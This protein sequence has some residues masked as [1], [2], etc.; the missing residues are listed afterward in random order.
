MIDW[1][2]LP[3]VPFDDIMTIV[4]HKSLA[5]LQSCSEVCTTWSV[6]IEKDIF[7]NP[8][9]MGTIRDK[10]ERAFGPEVK[11]DP[12]ND[13]GSRMLPNNEMISNAKWL[14]KYRLSLSFVDTHI[15]NQG[16]KNLINI[17]VL[18]SFAARVRKMLELNTSSS[19]SLLTCAGSLAFHGLLGQGYISL[20]LVDVNLS[21]VPAEYLAALARTLSWCGVTKVRGNDLISFLSHLDCYGLTITQSLSRDETQALVQAMES[22]V[23]KVRLKSVNFDVETLVTY[24]GEGFCGQVVIDYNYDYDPDYNYEDDYDP[25]RFREPLKDWAGLKDWAVI[26]LYGYQ[27]MVSNRISL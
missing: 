12:L 17:E 25:H 22:G 13:A 9:V 26:D 19:L 11:V 4:A 23:E 10:T 18:K 8:T 6:M 7:K 21:S 15:Y 3:R 16:D 2:Q 5:D 1:G 27:L 14:S 20:Y 24:S